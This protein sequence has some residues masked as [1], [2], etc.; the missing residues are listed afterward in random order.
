VGRDGIR[1]TVRGRLAV[2]AL[3]AMAAICLSVLYGGSN[4]SAHRTAPHGTVIV[5]DGDTLDSIA[6]RIAPD[7]DPADVVDKLR[8]VNRLSPSDLA[9][10]QPGQELLVGS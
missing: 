6:R 1:L 2:T 5:Q 7:D 10:L 3:L 4:A 9:H 8:A